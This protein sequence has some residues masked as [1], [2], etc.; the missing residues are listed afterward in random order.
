MKYFFIGDYNCFH[1]FSTKYSLNNNIPNFEKIL[2]VGSPCSRHPQM[3]TV[4]GYSGQTLHDLSFNITIYDIG[5]YN[6]EPLHLMLTPE[7]E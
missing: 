6:R 7:E 1:R 3:S 2:C 5:Y 4:A